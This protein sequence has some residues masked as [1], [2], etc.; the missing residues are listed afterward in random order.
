MRSGIVLFGLVVKRFVG[1][2]LVQLDRVITAILSVFGGLFEQYLCA[3]RDGLDWTA[4][5]GLPVDEFLAIGN[6][7]PAVWGE[8]LMPSEFMRGL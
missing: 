2:L 7:L 3:L 1:E 5:T 4:V 8:R 6:R